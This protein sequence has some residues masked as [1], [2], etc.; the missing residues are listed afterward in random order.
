MENCNNPVG[1]VSDKPSCIGNGLRR[2]GMRH[3][4]LFHVPH[5]EGHPNRRRLRNLGR[6]R[7]VLITLAAWFAHRQKLDAHAVPGIA[8]IVL[9]VLIINIFSKGI[10]R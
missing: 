7:I 3:F 8:M 6:A 2:S 5:L 1:Q 4:L 10:S 9:S